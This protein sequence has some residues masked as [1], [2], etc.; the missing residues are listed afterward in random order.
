MLRTAFY[1]AMNTVNSDPLLVMNVND[2]PE[3]VITPNHLLTQMTTQVPPLLVTLK[4]KMNAVG[5]GGNKFSLLNNS[6]N[7]GKWSI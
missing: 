7:D 1:E 2:P 6:G 4:T 5:L 3:S